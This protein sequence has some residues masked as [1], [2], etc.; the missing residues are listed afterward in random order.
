M[1]ELTANLSA[2]LAQDV[3]TLATCWSIARRDGVTWYLTAHDQDV[4]VDGNRYKAAP[5]MSTSAVTSQA[6]L[7]VD[8]LEFE[9]LLSADVITEADLLAGLYDHA[10]IRIF[11]VNYREPDAGLLHLKTGWLGEVT[12]RAGQFVAE[13][14]GISSRL[15]QVIGDVYTRAC[16]ATLGDA[17]CGVDLAAYRVTGTVTAV[18][19]A[20][21]FTDTS[22]GEAAGWFDYGAVTFTGGANA[23]LGMEVRD[24]KLG[25]FGLFLPMPHPIAVGDTYSATAGCDKMFDTCI[26]RYNNAVN[27]RGEPHVPGTDALLETSATRSS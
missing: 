18:E 9:G 13:V 14:R 4:I 8:N 15:Q 7:L 21:A 1:Q 20:Y 16:R 10:E 3:T 22:R 6:G 12:L 27:F 26:A 11:Q 2:H 5:G 23:G 25:R 17:R 24:F 19:T